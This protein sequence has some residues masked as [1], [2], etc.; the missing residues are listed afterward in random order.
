MSYM[1]WCRMC[2]YEAD[3]VVWGG[4]FFPVCI[5][6]HICIDATHEFI[7]HMR[8]CHICVYGA[9]CVVWVGSFFPVLILCHICI[10]IY[11]IYELMSHVRLRSWLC[12]LSRV[13]LSCVYFMSHLCVIHTVCMKVNCYPQMHF[14]QTTG[15]LMPP[16]ACHW[17]RLHPS[18]AAGTRP[19]ASQASCMLC[20]VDEPSWCTLCSTVPAWKYSDMV[21]RRRPARGWK[22]LFPPWQH[23]WCAIFCG[24]FYLWKG[25]I[26]KSDQFCR[27]KPTKVEGYNSAKCERIRAHDTSLKSPWCEDFDG[28]HVCSSLFE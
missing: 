14:F 16:S 3:C 13:L 20:P 7:S 4:S 11:V 23:W 6:C 1:N 22:E 17:E 25:H 26:D 12:R 5:L 21:H 19:F 8:L 10:W 24:D 2:V 27:T 18:S 15:A 9:D 28:I